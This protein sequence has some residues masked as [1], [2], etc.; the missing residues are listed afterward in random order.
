MASTGDVRYVVVIRSAG[1]RTVE[2]CKSLVL[3][4]I[5]EANLYV[6]DA[7]PFEAAL[8]RCYRIGIESGVEWM[9]TV[10]ADVLLRDGAIEGLLSEAC[11][12][13]KDHFQVEGLVFDKLTDRARWAGFRCYRVQYLGQAERLLPADR[14]EIRPEF[15]TLEA[16]AA[17]GYPYLRSARLY[18]LHDFE[19]YYR[20]I[21]RKALVHAEKHRAWLLDLLSRWK[22]AA[23]GD[24]DFRIALRGAADGLTAITSPRIDLRD[25]VET[26]VRAV[27]E[28]GLEE[29][30]ALSATD[31][32]SGYVETIIAD[33]LATSEQRVP[34]FRTT[35]TQRLAA[36]YAALGPWR[37]VPHL[38]GA[39]LVDIGR[40][41]K[42]CAERK[43]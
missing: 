16:M 10:D 15:A 25:Y 13:P 43:E 29:K 1:E 18:G 17:E 12:M 36:R 35:R 38:F 9:V 27:S 28:L 26:A 2:S 32:G 7:R 11:A 42:R 4:Q 34:E 37:F 14:A 23:V 33:S 5:P 30:P 19:Q 31:L 40:A 21:Y 39:A 22:L 8:R 20:D 6:V 3:Q 24:G 41:I